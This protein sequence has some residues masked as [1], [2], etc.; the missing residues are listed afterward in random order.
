MANG[1]LDA[2]AFTSSPQVQRLFEVAAATRREEALHT[3]LHGIRIGA[4]GPVV[5]EELR[6]RGVEVTVTPDHGYFMKPLVS[7]FLAAFSQ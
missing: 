7:A 6:R 5:A 3:A 1:A 2:I 4:V